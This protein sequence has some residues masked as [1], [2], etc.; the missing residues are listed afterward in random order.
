MLA[1]SMIEQKGF[2]DFMN[3][4]KTRSGYLM[5]L[6]EKKGRKQTKPTKRWVEIRGDEISWYKKK[7]GNASK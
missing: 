2:E 1:A 7:G 6:S 4:I 3:T 5:K